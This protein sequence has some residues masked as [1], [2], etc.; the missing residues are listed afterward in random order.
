MKF[1]KVKFSVGLFII[2]LVVLLF[3]FL[4]LLLKEKGTFDKRY[5]YNFSTDSAEYF[6][7]GM[8]LKFSGFNIGII[9]KITLKDNGSVKMDF[10]VTQKHKKWFNEGSILMINK[11]LIGSPYLEL[12][13]ALGTPPLED[14]SSMTMILSDDINDLIVKLQPI[15]KTA[16]HIL[17]NIDTITTYLAK[18]DSELKLMLINLNKFSNKLANDDS[19]LT[20]VTGDKKSTKDIINSI[21]TTSMLIQDMKNITAD[22]SKITSSLNKDIVTPASSSIKELDAIMKDIKKKLDTIDGTVN[23]IGSYD[24]ELLEIKDQVIVGIE[25]SNQLLDKVDSILAEDNANE[26]HMP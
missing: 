25:K 17:E 13:A 21:N 23:S 4:F 9:D 11:P 20:T 26:V 5:N 3:T 8:P 10:S 24:K 16:T 22:I 7:V 6:T 18:E 14:G 1:N 15:V 2:T 12:F 19:L